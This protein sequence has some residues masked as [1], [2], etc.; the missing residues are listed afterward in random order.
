MLNV[1][2]VQLM[3]NAVLAGAVFALWCSSLAGAVFALWCSSLAT[4]ARCGAVLRRV[5]V[6][7]VVGAVLGHVAVI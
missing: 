4:C 1:V 3:L 5:D 7:F 2:L 6:S